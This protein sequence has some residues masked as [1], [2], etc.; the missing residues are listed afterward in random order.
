MLK[1]T[2]GRLS[3]VQTDILKINKYHESFIELHDTRRTFQK[4]IIDLEFDI[5]KQE[6]EL[7]ILRRNRSA[8]SI[9]EEEEQELVESSPSKEEHANET[10]K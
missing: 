2:I 8:V 9:V 7:D 3:E 1:E 6:R 5:L 10:I 4:D